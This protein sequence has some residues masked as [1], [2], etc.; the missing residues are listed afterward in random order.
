MSDS[1]WPHQLQHAR[2]PCPSLSPR[3][4]SNSCPL[5]QWCHPTISFTVTLFSSWPQSFPHQGLFQWVASLHQVAKVLEHQSFQ[6]IFR[7]DLL[8]NRLV[9]YACSPRDS[10]ES[11]QHDSS[12]ALILWCSAFFM[13][14]LSY[15]YITIRKIAA[16]THRTDLCWQSDVFAF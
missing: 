1:L 9:G 8:Q 2:L 4:C 10:Q 3:I 13:V 15:L 6:W 12:K 16:L 11:L 5:S 14:Q 7:V